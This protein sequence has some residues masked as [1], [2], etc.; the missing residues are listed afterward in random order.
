MHPVIGH[1]IA[2]HMADPS[3]VVHPRHAGALP[4]AI[5]PPKNLGF[6]ER[7]LTVHSPE[8]DANGRWRERLNVCP[9]PPKARTQATVLQ[10]TVDERQGST[11]VKKEWMSEVI[12][13]VISES[14]TAARISI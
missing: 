14:F 5:R 2:F 11:C 10:T 1:W 8:R 6:L 13:G 7:Y 9:A 4:A 3:F 12:N